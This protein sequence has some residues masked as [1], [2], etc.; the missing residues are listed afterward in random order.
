MSLSCQ[1]SLVLMTVHSSIVKLIKFSLLNNVEKLIVKSLI[2]FILEVFGLFPCQRFVN[3]AVHFIRVNCN[4]HETLGLNNG[5]R[6]GNNPKTSQ[7][8]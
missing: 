3:I 5:S 6:Y 4:V 8:F 2:T 7:H 1:R